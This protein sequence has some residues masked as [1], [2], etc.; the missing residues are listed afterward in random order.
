[1][2]LSRQVGS[3]PSPRPLD[4]RTDR[5]A[6]V[7]SDRGARPR[8]SQIS[9]AN[10]LIEAA[11][12]TLI[13]NNLGPRVAETRRAGGLRRHRQGRAQLGLLRGHPEEPR[14][15]KRGRDPAGAV[16]QAG[17]R[18]PHPRDAPRVLQWPT[19]TWC[20]GATWKH[21]DELTARGLMMYGQMTAGSWI[22]IG[23]QGIVQGTYET[24]VEPAG[25]TTAAT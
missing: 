15:L 3:D 13:Q 6:T 1:M 10:W 17:G 20:R 5:P 25:N 18:V 24:F 23:S 16:G 9:C 22:Y 11:Y 12:R 4:V 7:A 14:E 2:N 19:A 8:G 21:F